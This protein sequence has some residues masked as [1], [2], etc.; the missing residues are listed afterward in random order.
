M[1]NKALK[2][3]KI[4]YISVT[5]IAIITATCMLLTGEM[6]IFLIGFSIVTA[7][8]LVMSYIDYKICNK[9]K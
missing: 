6:Y 1:P 2:I 9:D 7:F 5:I 8:S 3:R 4:A